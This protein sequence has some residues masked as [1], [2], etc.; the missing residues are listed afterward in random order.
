MAIHRLPLRVLV[1]LGVAIVLDTAT[2][3]LWKS[4]VLELPDVTEGWQQLA[5]ALQQPLLAGVVVLMILQFFNWRVVLSHCDLSFA[6][7]ITSLSYVTVAASSVLLLGERVDW[8][9]A[10]GI[11]LILA[12][13]WQVSGSGHATTLSGE[14]AADEPT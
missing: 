11:L 12:G 7:A 8:I 4:A 3:L 6:H 9:Q 10:A 14:R 1:G 13:V 5:L 2:Q